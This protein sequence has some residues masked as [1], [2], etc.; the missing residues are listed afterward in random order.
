MIIFS[1]NISSTSA[2][3]HGYDYLRVTSPPIPSHYGTWTKVVQLYDVVQ[4][5]DI[6]VLIDADAYFTNQ[7]ISIEFLMERYNFTDNT[8]LLM[9]EDP[10]GLINKDSKGRATLNTGFIIAQ[11]NNITTY[12]LKKLALCTR[13]IPGCDQWREKWSFEQRAFSDYIRDELKV[14]SELIVAPCTEVNGFA[15]SRSGCIGSF[16]SHIWTQKH[17]VGERLQ[18]TMLNSLMI[19]L[20]KKMWENNHSLIA[21]TSDIEELEARNNTTDIT[22]TAYKGQM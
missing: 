3:Y 19:S 12:I 5:Y 8:S 15:G 20:E 1:R 17:T 21:S 10:N 9:A 6:V 18:R 11:N 2:K 22:G 14:G 7:N 16:I 13:T 4:K